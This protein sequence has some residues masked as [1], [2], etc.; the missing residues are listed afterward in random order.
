M[1]KKVLEIAP[2]RVKALK[3]G[4]TVCL[5]TMSDPVKPDDGTHFKKRV[6]W[7]ENQT[8]IK[9]G[10]PECQGQAGNLVFKGEI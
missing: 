9:N 2:A 3:R 4:T 1:D 7:L 5:G 6:Q 10:R 8:G